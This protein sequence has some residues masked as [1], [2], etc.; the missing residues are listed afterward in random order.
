MLRITSW[1]ARLGQRLRADGSPRSQGDPSVAPA[2]RRRLPATRRRITKPTRKIHERFVKLGATGPCGTLD[3]RIGG[4]AQRARA[5]CSMGRAARCISTPPLRPDIWS[6]F[7]AGLPPLLR[8]AGR[9][10]RC[11]AGITGCPIMPTSTE[12]QPRRYR[13]EPFG[14]VGQRLAAVRP[15]RNE[16]A[17]NCRLSCRLS[18]ALLCTETFA[19]AFR[20]TILSYSRLSAAFSA[21]SRG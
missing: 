11:T 13:D 17:R 19:A 5:A 6:S 3:A 7:E 15:A 16:I 21:K 12:P 20:V 9:G 4:Q 2:A 14:Q 10:H 18:C 1:L 8:R